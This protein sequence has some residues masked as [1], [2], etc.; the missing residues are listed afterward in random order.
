MNKIIQPVV[1]GVIRKNGKYLFT[2][3]VDIDP[4]DKGIIS[5]FEGIWQLPGGGLEFGEDVEYCLRRELMEELGIEVEIKKLIPKLYHDVRNKVWHGL[6]ICFLCTMKNE[7]EKI[8]LNAESSEYKWL[9]YNEFKTYK[10]L[11][12]SKEL[13]AMAETL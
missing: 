5:E 11:P 13:V 8:V 6:L 10:T 3:R 1:I 9:T 4:E 2:R 12:F 7:D